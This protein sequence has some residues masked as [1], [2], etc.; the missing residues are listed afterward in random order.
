MGTEFC[1]YTQFS[2][3]VDGM[4]KRR[5]AAAF[6]VILLLCLGVYAGYRYHMTG[7]VNGVQPLRIRIDGTRYVICGAAETL[8][9]TPPDGT[10]TEIIDA[11]AYPE[12]DG[13][14][15]FGTIGMPYWYIGDKIVVASGQYYLFNES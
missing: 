12:K 11:I 6:A 7:R 9:N 15:N 5:I 10:I 8:P 14:A 13:Q 2:E 1:C 3:G 4:G